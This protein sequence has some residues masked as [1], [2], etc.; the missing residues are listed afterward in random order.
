MTRCLI[1]S[2]SVSLRRVLTV[3]LVVVGSL[4]G[5]VSGAEAAVDRRG[6]AVDALMG[7]YNT[8][9]GLWNTT[10]WWNSANV[11]T[12]VIDAER[13]TGKSTYRWAIANT[14]D[15][16]RLAQ[17]GNFINSY[18]DD[19]AWWGLAWL[20]AY[21]L[22]GDR[23]YLDT[24]R[25]DAD[26]MA[27]YWDDV[28]GGGVY[29][30]VEKTYKNAI[31]NELYLELNAALHNRIPGDMTYLQRAKD[32]WA[33][34]SASG[35][36]NSSHL[37]NDGLDLK[38]CRNNGQPVWSY[39][40]GVILGG[41]TH[42]YQATGDTNA[43][44]V[45]RQLANASTT[46]TTLNPNGILTDPCET[47]SDCGADGPSFKGA[48]ARGLGLLNTVL[49]SQPYTDYLCRQA[50]SAYTH[51]RNEADQY[52]LHWAG[53]LDFPDA[54]RQHSAVDLLNAAG[55]SSARASLG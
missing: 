54:A 43:L 14:Y 53:P 23:R 27:G 44:T 46:D 29:W 49:A 8:A 3:L 10:G 5:V 4:A 17:D 35:M 32:E 15:K 7:Y 2:V 38:T 39:N 36:I 22:T 9:T 40:Q 52:G 20:D 37:I 45:A 1:R 31:A 34:F 42:L 30:S 28:C 33:W 41:L 55:K 18:L 21:D 48:Y 24:A 11:L 19:A 6:P 13:A 16:N 50:D 51:D 26:F 25:A 12:A 47:A